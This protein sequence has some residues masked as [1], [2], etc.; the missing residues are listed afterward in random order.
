MTTEIVESWYNSLIDELQDIITEKVFEHTF[1]LIEC[2]HLVGTRIL[3][4]NDSFERSKI[5]GEKIVQRIAKSLNKKTRNFYYAIKFAKLYPDLNLL[6]EGKNVSWN[7]IINKYL[8]DGTEKKVVKKGDLYRMIKEI[9]ELLEH[10][11]L[12]A[13]NRMINIHL[14]GDDDVYHDKAKCEF[15]RYLQDQVNKITG[16]LNESSS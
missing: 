2:W 16:E 11:Y 14:S 12:D 6:P 3:Q 10:E 9:K 13:N 1:S 4:E 8:T 5:Y 7:H 15:I